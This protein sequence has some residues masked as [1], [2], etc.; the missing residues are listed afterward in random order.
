VAYTY[1]L[2]SYRPINTQ[3]MSQKNKK[4]SCR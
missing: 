1:K 2:L 3:Q 4:R